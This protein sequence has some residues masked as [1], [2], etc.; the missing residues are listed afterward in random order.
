M[1][2]E[3]PPECQLSISQPDEQPRSCWAAV[4]RPLALELRLCTVDR[5]SLPQSGKHTSCPKASFYNS[6]D[7]YISEISWAETRI[8]E[9]TCSVPDLQALVGTGR[10]CYAAT[11]GK[12]QD[13]RNEKESMHVLP[14]R[15]KDSAQVVWEGENTYDQIAKTLA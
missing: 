14:T 8:H 1:Y 11:P 3:I 6:N 12:D 15:E 7:F 2:A 5:S 13:P 10:E 9:L 4:K